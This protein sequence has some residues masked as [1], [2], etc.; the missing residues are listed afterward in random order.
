MRI[1]FLALILLCLFGSQSFAAKHTFEAG[2]LLGVST[3]ER[4][5]EGTSYRMAI[6]TVQVGDLVYTL[7][8]GHVNEKTPDYAN[9]LIVGDNVQVSVEGDNMYLLKPNGK[10]MK[11]A[12][13]K[14]ERK[15]L[16]Q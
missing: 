9:G 7:R 11:T 4:L 15:Q 16:A 6:L 13:M 1:R 8:G 2:K 12:I 5:F 3:D 14:R 10:D